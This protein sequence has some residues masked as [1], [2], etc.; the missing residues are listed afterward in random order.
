MRKLLKILICSVVC[1]ALLS[2]NVSFAKG[3]GPVEK[4][5]RGIANT[6]TGWVEL[7]LTLCES[8]EDNGI[9]AGIFFGIPVGFT[10]MFI[11]TGVGVYET[12]TFLLPFPNTYGPIVEPEFIIDSPFEKMSKEL[13]GTEIDDIRRT[14]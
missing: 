8:S 1:L 9:V 10:K 13:T 5:G 12:L 11:R 14:E 2:T 7:P 6:F 4:L 3:P